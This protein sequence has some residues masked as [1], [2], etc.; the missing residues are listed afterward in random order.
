[1]Y[2]NINN[3]IKK[4]LNNA[5]EEFEN[6]ENKERIFNS[7]VSPIFNKFLNRIYPYISFLFI[8]YIINLI[9]IIIILFVITKTRK[10]KE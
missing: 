9:L 7:I 1:M 10:I 8:I 4:I 6:D 3:F 2:K 5:L